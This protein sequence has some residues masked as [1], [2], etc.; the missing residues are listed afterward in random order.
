MDDI[1]VNYIT[2]YGKK[3]LFEPYAMTLQCA[4]C[5]HVQSLNPV[6]DDTGL[7]TSLTMDIS[8]ESHRDD[9][10]QRKVKLSLQEFAALEYGRGKYYAPIYAKYRTKKIRDYDL[11]TGDFAGWKAI[12][13]GIG[14]CVG[15]EYIGYFEA[16]LVDSI[17]NSNV[18]MK[19]VLK[20]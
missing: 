4:Y 9:C 3:W 13:V 10:P 7:V 2:A 18:L 1:P 14:E 16:R 8:Q 19:R 11:D 17:L 12:Q 6:R 5:I 20:K 15:Y